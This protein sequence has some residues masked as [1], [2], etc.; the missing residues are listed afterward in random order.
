VLGRIASFAIARRRLILVSALILF[1]VAGAV[2]G[3]VD[4]SQ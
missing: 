3:N 1:F 4:A 2:G